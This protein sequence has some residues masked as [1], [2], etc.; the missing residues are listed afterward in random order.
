MIII[1]AI[2]L[3]IEFI[4][5]TLLVSIVTNKASQQEINPTDTLPKSI[6]AI[7]SPLYAENDVYYYR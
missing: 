1:D 5:P 4:G 3:T 6:Y 2:I 7:M